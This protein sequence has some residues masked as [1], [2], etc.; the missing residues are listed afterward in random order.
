MT[1]NIATKKNYNVIVYVAPFNLIL[2]RESTELS[3]IP[4]VLN[5]DSTILKNI[6]LILLIYVEL[7]C[8]ELV[9]SSKHFVLFSIFLLIL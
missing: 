1:V 4:F 2:R 5:L 7:T 6:F 3:K 8:K 9:D